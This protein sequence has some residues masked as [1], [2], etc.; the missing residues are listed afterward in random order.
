MTITFGA[1][2]TFVILF[3]HVITLGA[4]DTS[5]DRKATNLI[6]AL[7]KKLINVILNQS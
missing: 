6:L 7:L 5:A 1:R 3:V 2:Y 4:T